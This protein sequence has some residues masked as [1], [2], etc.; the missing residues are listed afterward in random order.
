MSERQQRKAR[1]Q[2]RQG[3]MLC[4]VAPTRPDPGPAANSIAPELRRFYANRRVAVVEYLRGERPRGNELAP[5]E[6]VDRVHNEWRQQFASRNVPG[7][8][9]AER[10]FWFALFLIEE[11]DVLGDVHIFETDPVTNTPRANQLGAEM[12][13][14]MLEVARLLELGKPLPPSTM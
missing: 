6:F 3:S 8:V 10:T 2:K 12:R 11:H 4:I 5:H 1:Q 9:P 13:V 14:E 7:T